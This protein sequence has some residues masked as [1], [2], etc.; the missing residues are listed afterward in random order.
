MDELDGIINQAGMVDGE[1]AAS[2]PGAVMEAQ[3][4]AE[5]MSL[6]AENTAGVGFILGM[7]VPLIGK[8]YPSLLEV[9]TPKACS[10]VGAAMGPVL[11]KYGVNLKELGGA[12]KEEVAALFVCGP[13][14][15]ATVAGIKADIA[16]RARPAAA[17]VAAP[18]RPGNLPVPGD[19][20]YREPEA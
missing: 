10:A 1:V 8:M 14:A 19:F 15:W 5:V 18:P 3:A 20:D 17:Q 7:A 11:A 16:A 13:I 9:Y 12:Y 2:A 6:A 4:E